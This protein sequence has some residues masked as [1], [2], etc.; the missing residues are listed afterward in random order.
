M[1]SNRLS[2]TTSITTTR[3][4]IHV[5]I[6]PFGTIKQVVRTSIRMQF[7]MESQYINIK[8]NIQRSLDHFFGSRLRYYY[9]A[10]FLFAK[11]LL[12]NINFYRIQNRNRWIP[13]LM[14]GFYFHIHKSVIFQP[15]ISEIHFC[16]KGFFHSDYTFAAEK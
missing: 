10:W 16:V 8:Q 3:I 12:F 2:L 1:I 15:P 11:H 14:H 9:I 4:V 7:I 5:I 13:G 6:P